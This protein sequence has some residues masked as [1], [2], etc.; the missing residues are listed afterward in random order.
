MDESALQ[1]RLDRIRQRQYLILILL[2]VPSLFRI[3]EQIGVWVAG[4]L[5]I[6]SS[7]ILLVIVVFYRRRNRNTVGQSA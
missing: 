1:D 2:I 3:A 7:F 4:A 5:F 6:A